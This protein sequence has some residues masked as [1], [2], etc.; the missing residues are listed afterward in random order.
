VA[1]TDLFVG[2][3]SGWLSSPD[4]AAKVYQRASLPAPATS[5]RKLGRVF[6]VQRHGGQ[7][8]GVRFRAR[9]ADDATRI[10]NALRDE[11]GERSTALAAGSPTFAFRVS[12][13]EPLV[14]PVR[15]YPALRGLISGIVILAV[16]LN[17]VF[18][19]DFLRS[20]SVPSSWG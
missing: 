16:G 19:R 2:T 4:F 11:V 18:L 7:V 1:A 12:V 6:T 10:A 8:V 3:L 15:P 13:G 5:V 17:A 14:V 9:T 20:P